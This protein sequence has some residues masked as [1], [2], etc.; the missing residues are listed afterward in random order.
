[1]K[2]RPFSEARDT[3]YNNCKFL[4][5]YNIPQQKLIIMPPLFPPRPTLDS[6]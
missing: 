1:V 3:F 2:F 4:A 6:E 5:E